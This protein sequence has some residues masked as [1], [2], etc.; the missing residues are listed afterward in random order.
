MCAS[1][2]QQQKPHSLSPSLSF[3]L[4][5]PSPF[6]SLSHSL[7]CITSKSP[8]IINLSYGSFAVSKTIFR[9]L[10]R[11][12]EKSQPQ[13]RSFYP[14]CKRHHSF[15]DA[16]LRRWELVL[17]YSTFVPA[18]SGWGWGSSFPLNF[19]RIVIPSLGVTFETLVPM[20]NPFQW[21]LN[22]WE[23]GQSPGLLRISRTLMYGSTA[24]VYFTPFLFI[25]LMFI[26]LLFLLPGQ[27][28]LQEACWSG[29]P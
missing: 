3:S 10:A 23:Q 18:A 12:P 15:S 21:N 22:A 19:I 20:L 25:T 24:F 16:F 26:L 5:F 13:P 7:F 9:S 2:K 27:A 17:L 28:G 6:L 29:P 1:L 8:S 11:G 14:Q 4:P